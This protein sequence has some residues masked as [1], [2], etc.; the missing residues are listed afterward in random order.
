MAGL[1]RLENGSCPVAAQEP[2]GSGQGLTEP[3]PRAV[4]HGLGFVDFG[5]PTL[6]VLAVQGADGFPRRGASAAETRKKNR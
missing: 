4:G 3:A 2:S 5:R 1:P 6:E